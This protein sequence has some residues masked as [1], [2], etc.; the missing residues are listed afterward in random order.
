MDRI[1]EVHADGSPPR[2][3]ALTAPARIAS[4]ALLGERKEVV[5]VHNG[6]EYRLRQTQSG[7]LILTA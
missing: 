6:R 3:D 2:T 5:I 4:R 7:K 1:R